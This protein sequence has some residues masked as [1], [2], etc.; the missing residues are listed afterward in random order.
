MAPPRLATPADW[1][2]REFALP[3]TAVDWPPVVIPNR[4]ARHHARRARADARRQR[5][6]LASG[7]AGCVLLV[8]AVLYVWGGG[9]LG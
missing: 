5:V 1:P 9:P 4:A 6:A 3:A 2:T 8:S 7:L